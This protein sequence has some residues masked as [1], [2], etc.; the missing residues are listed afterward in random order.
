[1]TR[2][3]TI[4]TG[5]GVELPEATSIETPW[6][7]L[8]AR[9][10]S[11]LVALKGLDPEADPGRGCV[12][13]TRVDDPWV[14]GTDGQPALRLLG[15]EDPRW[16]RVALG[17]LLAQDPSA[18]RPTLPWCCVET[19]DGGGGG[20]A[21]RQFIKGNTVAESQVPEL[22]RWLSLVGN[23]RLPDIAVNRATSMAGR[24]TDHID[25]LIDGVIVW[26]NLLGTGDIQELSYRVSMTMACVLSQ[27]P[28]QRVAYQLEI[29]QLYNLRSKIV[30]GGLHLQSGEDREKR[31]RVQELTL[32]AMRALLDKHPSLVGATPP[33]LVAFILGANAIPHQGSSQPQQG[34]TP[35]PPEMSR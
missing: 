34:L 31:D 4:L 35:K 20:S 17:L 6:G 32:L 10:S 26:E 19:L 13:E 15:I 24:L 14:V 2:G 11:D 3:L 5:F 27:E 12:L 29:K 21:F 30:H 25:A 28:G 23:Q 7:V 8:R 9:R 1:M 16:K 33:G 22:T 18:A